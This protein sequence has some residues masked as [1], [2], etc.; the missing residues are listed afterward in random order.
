VFRRVADRAVASP[1]GVPPLTLHSPSRTSSVFRSVAPGRQA[2]AVRSLRPSSR[3]F[4]CPYG[5]PSPRNPLPGT[6]SSPGA[7]LR[8]SPPVRLRSS[9]PRS[10]SDGPAVP[11]RGLP[12]PLR[13]ASA[14]SHDPGGLLLLEPGGVFRP[15][16]PVGFGSRLP[17]ACLRSSGPRTFLPGARPHGPHRGTCHAFAGGELSF[18]RLPVDSAPDSCRSIHP[19]CEATAP[20]PEGVVPASG[21]PA[22]LRAVSVP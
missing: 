9:H 11:R 12:H 1:V 19:G 10:R 22:W 21:S 4:A 3:R 20:T 18:W 8:L 6:V 15:L 17:A 13:S 16:T 14:V 2:T 7:G 5:A